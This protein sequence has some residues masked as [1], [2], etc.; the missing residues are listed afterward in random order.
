MKNRK[1]NTEETVVFQLLKGVIDPELMINV[2]DLGLVYDVRIKD[3]KIT[4]DLTL[5]SPGCPMG[6]MIIGD[7]KQ[8]ISSNY[9]DYAVVVNLV[10]SPVW[11][12]ANLT[13]EGKEALGQA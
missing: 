6:E 7:V 2:V 12:I 4:I 1:L 8:I 11:S 9:L 5:T 13:P 10:W 3:E